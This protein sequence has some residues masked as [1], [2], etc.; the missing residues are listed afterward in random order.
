M[1]RF[2]IVS[3]PPAA[4]GYLPRLRFMCDYLVQ[5]GYDATLLTEQYQSIDFAH[6]YPIQ[7]VCM[8]TGGTLDWLIKSVWTL[9]TDWHDRVFAKRALPH[10]QGHYD[11]VICTAFSYF[12]LG[13]AQR[14]AQY[15]HVPLICDIRDLD[16]QVDN[17]RYQ[18]RHQNKWLMP[19]R[20]IYRAIHIHRRNKVLKTANAITTVSPWHAE[21]I[22]QFNS[23]VH[24]V[25]NGYDAKQFYPEDIPAKQFIVSYI[26]SLTDWQRPALAIVQQAIK[27][28]DI[29]IILEIHTPHR[30]TIPHTQMGE[31]IRRSSIMLV[32]TATH[33]HGMLTTKFYEALGCEKPILCVPSDKGS[34]V[35]LIKYTH[36]GLATDNIEEIK[37]FIRACYN[38]WQQ[39]GFTHQPT[40]HRNEFNRNNQNAKLL[41]LIHNL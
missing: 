23:N 28:L 24:V 34:L 36:A 17:S 30:N 15:L 9:M 13:A 32:F 2:L 37:T 39:N 20:H 31:A 12:P 35:E 25:Y 16:E 40:R 14:I 5:K 4:P 19:F 33:T 1:K 22:R 7:T 3:D 38:E 10:I 26:G 21:F 29:P 27:E 18:Y 11:A 8:F 41:E 6:S